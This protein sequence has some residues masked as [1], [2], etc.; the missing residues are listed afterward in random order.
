[1]IKFNLL[2]AAFTA[3]ERYRMRHPDRLKLATKRWRERNHE[4]HRANLRAWQDR[5]KEKLAERK[6]KKYHSNPEFFRQ[7]RRERIAKLTPEELAA[8]KAKTREYNQGY[9]QRPGVAEREKERSRKRLKRPDVKKRKKQL[10]ATPENKARHAMRQQQYRKTPKGSIDSRMSRSIRQSLCGMKRGR[11]WESLVGY[12]IDDLFKHLEAHFSPGM[13]WKRFVRGQI[14]IDHVIPKSKFHYTSDGDLNFKRC[15]AL[16]NLKP[17]WA[18][19]NLAKHD[20]VLC[21]SQ[22]PLGV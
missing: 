1:V 17:A 15:W 2:N 8:H 5:N 22:I 14:H 7:K 9:Y 4:R 21:P 3:E 20:T 10:A 18:K 16:E 6:L 12:S 13:N 11:K 19:H